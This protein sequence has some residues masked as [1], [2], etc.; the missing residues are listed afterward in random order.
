MPRLP[1]ARSLKLLRLAASTPRP[2]TATCTL[3]TTSSAR[4]ET[5]S[6]VRRKLWRSE[7]P[8]P[9][10]PYTQR[11]EATQPAPD[12]EETTKPA[13]VARDNTPKSIRRSRLIVPPR[14]TEAATPE[15][16]K[17]RDPNYVPAEDGKDLELIATLDNWWQRPGHWGEESKFK[18]FG[19]STIVTNRAVIEATLC[20]AFFEVT[21]LQQTGHFAEWMAKPWYVGG[22]KALRLILETKFPAKDTTL[23]NF[24]ASHISQHVRGTADRSEDDETH[25]MSVEE[26]QEAIK[27]WGSKMREIQ[28]SDEAK[29]AIR[30]RVYQLTGNLIADSKLGA[31]R[32]LR[33]LLLVTGKEPKP[34]RLTVELRERGELDSLPNVT[35]HKQRVGIITKETNLGRWKLI[36]QELG[37]RGLPERGPANASG[38]VEAK[39]LSGRA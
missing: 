24:N 29:F 31:S 28:L 14:R 18:G 2:A 16:A 11:S 8:G 6:W 20:R 22:K 19:N 39:W 35:V 33:D 36:Q 34:M 3:T 9:E 23:H 27:Q 25:R 37:K 32:T 7:P 21:A 26:A 1:G 30:K 4:G 15:Q 38:L 10:D 13:R 5:T 17:E 12:T